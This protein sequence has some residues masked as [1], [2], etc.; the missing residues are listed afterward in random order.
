MTVHDSSASYSIARP[1]KRPLVLTIAPVEASGLLD[2]ELNVWI[3][4]AVKMEI[5][6]CVCAQ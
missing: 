1:L 2:L 4:S 3:V 5:T 6:S